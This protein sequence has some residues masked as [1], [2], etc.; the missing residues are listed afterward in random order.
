MTDLAKLVV[1]LEAEIGKYQTNL[2]K[3]TAQ[4]RQFQEDAESTFQ[5]IGNAVTAYLTFDRLQAWG[6]HILDNGDHLQ[7][8]SQSSGIAVERLSQL[9]HAFE[10][11]GVDA[12]ALG[13]LLRKLN[14]NISDA[15][16]N[17]KSDAAV[18]FRALGISARD[19]ADKVKS[20]DQVLLEIADRFQ[21]YV[22]GA[23]KS[24]IATQLLGKSGAE[25]IPF[26][27]QGSAGIKALADESDRL[28]ITLS[29]KTAA[30][31]EEFNDRVDR[32]KSL[33][34][35]GIGN[36]VAARLLPTLNAMGSELEDTA[37]SA[38]ELDAAVEPLVAGIKLL[39]SVGIVAG[40]VIESLGNHIG[41]VAA[42]ATSFFTGN[43]AQA[44]RILR[45]EFD[46][47]TEIAG[48]TIDRL[49]T[50]WREGGDDILREVKTTSSKIKD[51]APNLAGGKEAQKAT[52]DAIKKLTE[53]NA[54]IAEQVQTF[55]FGEAAALK[56]RL[57]IGNLADDVAKAG[58]K[59][60]ALRDSIIAQAE[61]LQRLK[62]TKEIT[63]ALGEVTAQ[64]ETIRGNSADAAVAA[65][66]AKNAELI[67]KLRHDG[68]VEG[69]KQLETLLTLTVAQADYNEGLQAQQK[70]ED[71]LQST[72]ERLRN[73]RDAGAI[74]ELQYQKQLGD[75]R[76]QAA[77]DLDQVAKSQ[78]KI[79]EQIGNP[80]LIEDTQKL[81]DQ[82]A[83]LRTQADLVAQSI[84]TG[85]EDAFS[86][87]ADSVILGTKKAS[88]ALH[89]FFSDLAAQLVHLA[90][91][92]IA[93]SI[94]GTL[95]S[96]TAGGGSTTG[97]IF[98]T[99]AGLFA[100]GAAVGR[101]VN[102]GMAYAI[103][104]T[105]GPR[106]SEWFIPKR[107]GAVVPASKLGGSNVTNRISVSIASPS[108]QVSRSTQ[109]E[110]AARVARAVTL[111]S[112]RNN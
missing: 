72:E 98:S 71:Q 41:A 87:A 48:K 29:G 102:E 68:N 25:A 54:Q 73:S 37:G 59:G 50:L 28:G 112:R 91:Q 69:Q 8:F 23:N 31:A 52:E 26:L 74:T 46:Q 19:G 70:I 89:D 64:I 62:D 11:S 105:S 84:R 33:L 10:A 12:D 14:D 13:G 3:A 81:G 92:N 86:S 51:E 65:F 22:D 61:A 36:Q 93:Q 101:D 104:G 2:Y 42:A 47:Q 55:G 9:Q 94:F 17:A 38:S 106:D 5:K 75:A 45:D 97:G 43:F 16:G 90:T 30:A 60:I 34:I 27:N 88:E 57:E 39:I 56:Y 24:A 110:T 15:A 49:A 18:A 58:E 7:K 66:D 83:T 107:D 76:R 67:T 79:A 111:A 32:L 95:G 35:D 77:A 20:A 82:I 99:L 100:G 109:L 4:L 80:K 108:G 44:G 53:L 96:S 6:Q 78:E 21:N 1:R 63:K 40:S 85:F 103:S